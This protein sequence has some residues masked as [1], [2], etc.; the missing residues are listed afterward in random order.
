VKKSATVS[1]F[2]TVAVRVT[3]SEH[4][5]FFP[6]RDREGVGVLLHADK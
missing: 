2:L 5:T 4:A 6:N 3:L 1:D